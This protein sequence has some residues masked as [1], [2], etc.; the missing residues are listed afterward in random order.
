[1]HSESREGG[2]QDVLPDLRP[3]LVVVVSQSYYNPGKFDDTNLQ[4]VG[5]SRES[6]KQLLRHTTRQTLDKFHQLGT[7]VLIVHNTIKAKAMIY[8]LAAA[9]Y[10]E[11]CLI[12]APTARDPSDG[13]YEAEDVARDDVFTVDVNPDIC[14]DAPLC[15]PILDGR[16]VW[17]EY[18]LTVSITVHLRDK[19][20]NRISDTGALAGFGIKGSS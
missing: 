10:I 12:A 14:P 5:G 7:R 9:T 17:R 3:D 11:E 4:R 8:R 19:I 13:F 2:D 15:R 1:M 16:V 20:W 6:V 18:D